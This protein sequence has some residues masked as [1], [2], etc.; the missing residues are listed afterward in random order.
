MTDT[1]KNNALPQFFVIPLFNKK[2]HNNS[3]LQ[4]LEK[5]PFSRA[6]EHFLKLIMANPGGIFLSK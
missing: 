5:Q 4:R 2:L 6:F 3:F 1:Q